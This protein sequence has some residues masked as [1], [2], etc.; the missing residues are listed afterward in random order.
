MPCTYY[1]FS[2][3]WQEKVRKTLWDL[4]HRGFA[5][6]SDGELYPK[7]KFAWQLQSYRE[8]VAINNSLQDDYG[9]RLVWKSQEVKGRSKSMDEW[10][11]YPIGRGKM[12]KTN[13]FGIP[14][15]KNMC[16]VCWS[17]GPW[18]T[19]CRLKE[20]VFE[21]W[22]P[23]L[24]VL[25]PA[26]KLRKFFPLRNIVCDKYKDEKDEHQRYYPAIAFAEYGAISSQI[27]E[28]NAAKYKDAKKQNP[29]EYPE[30]EPPEDERGEQPVPPGDEVVPYA[31]SKKNSKAFRN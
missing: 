15:N 30:I 25:Q 3:E 17:E 14:P 2:P 29:E 23:A 28:L 21:L 24:T 11:C 20:M 8:F 26:E 1:P 9:I 13:R 22:E 4:S 10:H 5:E 12:E 6:N 16:A 18:K 7:R 31:A 19:E 27:R